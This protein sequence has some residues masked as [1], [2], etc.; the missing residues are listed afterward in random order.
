MRGHAF[1]MGRNWSGWSEVKMRRVSKDSSVQVINNKYYKLYFYDSSGGMHMLDNHPL[2]PY[3]IPSRLK[4]KYR[5][6]IKC[7]CFTEASPQHARDL[8]NS[9]GR[10]VRL[11]CLC[12]IK[13]ETLRGLNELLWDNCC[14]SLL[15]DN[16]CLLKRY[17]ILMPGSHESISHSVVSDSWWLHGL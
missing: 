11:T 1:S 3:H 12:L 14:G 5:A 2:W 8:P 15:W 7:L 4:T 16:L 9:P 13:E 6:V 10:Q 17:E